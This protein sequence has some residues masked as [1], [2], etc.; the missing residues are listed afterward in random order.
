MSSQRL[1]L[2]SQSP[3]RADLLR[4]AGYTFEVLP[5][6]VSEPIPRSGAT[7]PEH[8]AEALSYFKARDV[9]RQLQ[10]GVVLAADTLV[11]GDGAIFGKPLDE[12]DARQTLLALCGTTHRVITGV[13]VLEVASG[14]RLIQHESSVVTMRPMAPEVLEAYLT[15][16]RW[17]GKAGG[18]GIQDRSDAQVE[19]IEGSVSNVMGLPLE[20]IGPMLA[21]FGV[22]PDH[23]AA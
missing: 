22:L 10:D 13:A 5:S 2:A 18:Y 23:P 4:Q 15:S 21:Q 6:T 16:G 14:R 8:W 20:R 1:I 7:R 3:R 17:Q 9:A 12:T 11:A 19:C